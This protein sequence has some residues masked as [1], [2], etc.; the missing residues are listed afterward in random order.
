MIINGGYHNGDFKPTG[1][2]KSKEKIY[3]KFDDDLSGIIYIED[4]ILNM[5]WVKNFSNP[6]FDAS[7]NVL[8]ADPFII[9][10][11]NINGINSDTKILDKRTII[12]KD[13]DENV[14]F[15][16]FPTK[17]ISLFGVMQIFQFLNMKVCLNLDGGTSIGFY[18]LM[19][20]SK[21]YLLSC[22]KIPNVI[23]VFRK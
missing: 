16:V 10:P 2:L 12:A 13:N 7:E 18:L 21:Y 14:V 3:G 1:I 11:N 22:R 6:K 19:S 20:N 9:E 4:N 5:D 23:A 15:A 17:S 8:Q